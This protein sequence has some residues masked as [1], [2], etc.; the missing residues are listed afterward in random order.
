MALLDGTSGYS[1]G[2]TSWSAPPAPTPSRCSWTGATTTDLG[3]SGTS[4]TDAAS[5]ASNMDLI[6]TA[7]TAGVGDAG[8]CRRDPVPFRFPGRRDQHLAG[9]PCNRRSH[10][11]RT[12]ISRPSRPTSPTIRR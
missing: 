8:Q 2:V 4:I 7:I 11:S 5:A 3:I 12:S 6:N 1:A 10:R 9:E